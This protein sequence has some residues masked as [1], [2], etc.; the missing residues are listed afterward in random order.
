MGQK[1]LIAYCGM[2]HAM[3]P[4]QVNKTSN[5]Q[6]MLLN[7]PKTSKWQNE[8]NDQTKIRL[9]GLSV[10]FVRNEAIR[11]KQLINVSTSEACQ[12]IKKAAKLTAM[13]I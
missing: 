9:T 2:T 3:L 5:I 1:L 10:S 12:S 6:L 7:R 4:I 13:K 8:F 11:R